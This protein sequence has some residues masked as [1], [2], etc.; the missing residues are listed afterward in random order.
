M[1]NNI[2]YSRIGISYYILYTA[3][4]YVEQK[5]YELGP[6]LAWE[7]ITIYGTWAEDLLLEYYTH[8]FDILRNVWTI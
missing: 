8:W 2:L 1:Y 3:M 4:I 6:K 7:Y 5:R